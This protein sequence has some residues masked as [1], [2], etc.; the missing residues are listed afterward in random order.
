MRRL[1]LQ[2]PMPLPPLS[3]SQRGGGVCLSLESDP[4]PFFAER[5]EWSFCTGQSEPVL[6]GDHPGP[7]TRS[8]ANRLGTLPTF[9]LSGS[10]L[11]VTGCA[12][13]AE[14]AARAKA[15]QP[16]PKTRR[17]RAGK[18]GDW[19]AAV[20]LEAPRLRVCNRH[21]SGPRSRGGSDSD[22]RLALPPLAMLG[23]RRAP[24]LR[25][26]PGHGPGRGAPAVTVTLPAGWGGRCGSHGP[27]WAGPVWAGAPAMSPGSSE[28]SVRQRG[29]FEATIA[30]TGLS[31][32]GSWLR[33]LRARSLRR[34]PPGSARR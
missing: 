14:A 16:G 23:A 8:A 4:R 26:D 9:K 18:R 17:R 6:C 5:S 10:R 24:G 12:R 3:G 30:R 7:S 34:R 22:R 2:R 20:A 27:G 1:P 25:W 21:A 31:A 19:L 11:G 28:F 32:R 29:F 13:P 33:A 15:S